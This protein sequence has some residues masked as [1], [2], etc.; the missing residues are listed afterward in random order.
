MS[1]ITVNSYNIYV[2]FNFYNMCYIG[3]VEINI[4]LKDN[5]NLI[6]LNANQLK[7]LDLQVNNE[8]KEYIYNS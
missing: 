5:C 2:A 8:K 7:I 6:I 1:N 3:K 4:I